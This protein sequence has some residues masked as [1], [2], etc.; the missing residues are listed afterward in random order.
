MFLLKW[1]QDELD[2]L[3]LHEERGYWPVNHTGTQSYT[4]TMTF[5]IDWYV[6]TSNISSDNFEHSE[7]RCNFYIIIGICCS[8]IYRLLFL[9][10]GYL[11]IMKRFTFQC[12]FLFL[13][14]WHWWSL[15]II[16]IYLT[17]YPICW[18]YTMHAQLLA[19]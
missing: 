8:S 10:L 2:N 12:F 18:I 4:N 14:I 11:N 16:S 5:R 9:P 1:H 7:G 17:L 15:E 6:Q 19:E 3:F 13:R